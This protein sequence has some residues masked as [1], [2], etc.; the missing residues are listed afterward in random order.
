[1]CCATHRLLAVLIVT[2]SICASAKDGPIAA[3]VLF[4]AMHGPA[5]VQLTGVTLNG[6][7]EVRFCDNIVNFDEK[8]YKALPRTSFAGASSLQRGKDGV[9]TLTVNSRSRC[10]VPSKLKFDRKPKLTP[11]EAAEGSVLYGTPV[12]SSE[13]DARIPEVTPGVQLVFVTAPDVEVAEFLRAKRASTIEGWE[14]F[15]ARYPSSAHTTDARNSL[16]GLFQ[17]AAEAAFAQYQ[18]A[19]ADHKQDLDMLRQARMQAQ[20]AKQASAGYSPS[21]KLLDAV[22]RELDRLLEI[23][24]A[25]LQV[26]Q[27]GLR[28]QSC[29]YS[30]LLAA[31][32]HVEQ[33]LTVQPDYAPLLNVHREI[34]AEEGKI[35]TT[36][37]NA[38]RLT[39]STR[40]DDAVNAL[41]PYSCLAPEV[42]RIDAVVMAAYKYH[43]DRGERMAAVQDWNNAVAEFRIAAS[44]RPDSKEASNVLDLATFQLTTKQNQEGAK[45]ALEESNESASKNRFIEAYEVLANLPDQERMLVSSQL[46]ALTSSYVSAATGSAQK[47][48]AE[49]IPIKNRG[50][51]DAV[52]EAYALLDR[53]S[54][55]TGDPATTVKRDLLSSKISA[56]YVEEASRYLQTPSGAGAGIGCLYLK[57]AQRYAITNLDDVNDQII[58]YAGLCRR[59]TGLSVGIV[60][61]DQTSRRDGPSFADQL[62]DAIA[63]GLES[64]GVAVE[65]VRNPSELAQSLQ[66]S[67]KIIGE[68]LEHRVMKSVTIDAPESKYRAGTHETK[69]PAWLQATSDYRSA[70]QELMAAQ[71]ALADM[72]SQHKSKSIIAAANDTV[73]RAQKR[74]DELRQKLDRTDEGRVEAIIE[75]Y[76]YTK[77]TVDLS[78]AIQLTFVL[79]DRSGTL[80]GHIDNIRKTNHKIDVVLED[81]KAE[82]TEGITNHGA[83]PDATQFLTD[84]ELEIRDVLVDTVRRK[85]A[86]MPSDALQE[87][88]SNLRR[89]DIDGAAEQY[90]M[91]LD[92]T[93]ETTPERAEAAKFLRDRFS[94]TVPF[95]KF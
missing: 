17:K 71:Q 55:L 48:Q 77:K 58:Q 81:V 11:A 52:R 80:I 4:D 44:L 6:Q 75:P 42:S 24:R 9:L 57:Q 93:P 73:Q 45:L 7:T 82:D 59:R 47:I 61:R 70:Q 62:V 50:D 94:L 67:F 28:D 39:A 1:M 35:E 21:A 14:D 3:V 72:R 92:S 23:D 38:E 91:Y 2:A 29:K 12:G 66:P 79:S 18:Q 63:N 60:L 19:S 40:H 78:A 31:R 89:G 16:A 25:R 22:A 46:S 86:E 32:M 34:A 83:D 36:I 54:S 69:N 90:I 74:L 15:L 10:V 13:R 68:V 43:F 84:L 49:H 64:S 76:H 41:R 33:L 5:Y 87:A 30:Q 53:V 56:Y 20:A 27:R 95:S 85:A 88:R 8:T 65:V 26:F 37:I 51:E